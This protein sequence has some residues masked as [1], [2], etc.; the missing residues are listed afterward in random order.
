MSI[1][2]IPY[3]YFDSIEPGNKIEFIKR[4]LECMSCKDV[5]ANLCRGK[6]VKDENERCCLVECVMKLERRKS[7]RKFELSKRDILYIVEKD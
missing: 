6:V 2:W 3:Q 4:E 1:S 7:N 5:T